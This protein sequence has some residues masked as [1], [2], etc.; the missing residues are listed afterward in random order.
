MRILL[1]A[2]SFS[3]AMSGVQRH[4]FNIVR[5][6]LKHP[7]VSAVDLVVAPWQR[8]LLQSAGVACDARVSVHTA[9]MERSS[10]SRNLWYYRQLPRIAASLCADLVHLSYPMPV[11]RSAL[12]CPVVVTLHDLYPYEIPMNFGFPKF[13]FNRSVLQQCLRCA[14]ALACVSE[15]TRQAVKKYAP[16]TVW[17]KSVRIY[18]CV[19]PTPLRA[20]TSPIP[21]WD[22]EPFLVCV[23]QHRRNKNLPLLIRTFVQ[24]LETRSINPRM[25]LVIVGIRGPETKSIEELIAVHRLDGR[26]HLLEGL[27]EE[28]LQ[29]CY[30]HGEAVVVPSSTEG[31]GLPVAE[32]ILVGCRVVC[33][34]IPA[35]RE[36]GGAHCR[37]ISLEGDK[38][39]NLAEG[40]RTVLREPA[41][42]SVPLPQFSSDVL[43]QQYIALYRGL[44]RNPE[45]SRDTAPAS[46]LRAIAS[47]QESI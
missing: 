23:A 20:T 26:A 13:L 1:T 2:A 10:L 14:D 25:N 16:T 4:A 28:Q 12:R 19:E 17:R 45:R 8:N 27:S 31:F 18:N 9:E 11:N 24:L 34:D 40:I 15:S 32:A 3:S 38:V 46:S 22:G 30:A 35:L 7:D 36:V 39:A 44:L 37:F 5:C 42:R 43:A 33:S 6:L 21:R 47:E 29:W 41:P